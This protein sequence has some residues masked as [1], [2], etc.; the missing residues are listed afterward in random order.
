MEPTPLFV[1]Y[2]T[3]STYQ[4]SHT[5]FVFVFIYI[6]LFLFIYGLLFIGKDIDFWIN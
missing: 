6:N 4:E 2:K 3:D 5:W 1:N